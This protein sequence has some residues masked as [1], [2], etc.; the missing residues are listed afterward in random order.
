MITLFITLATIGIF[1]AHAVQNDDTE[2]VYTET[3]IVKK[4]VIAYD[5]PKVDYSQIKGNK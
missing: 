4:E 1:G 5:S 3:V 2:T